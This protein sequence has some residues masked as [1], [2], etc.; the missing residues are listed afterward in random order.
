[1]KKPRGLGDVLIEER[2]IGEEQLVQAQRAALRQGSPLVTVLLE[3]NL[4]SESDLVEAI[5][6]RV[7]IPLFDPASTPVDPDAV[8]EVPYEEANRNRLLPVRMLQRGD[9]R[10]LKVAMADPLDAQAIE[11]LEF[12]S[13]AEVEPLVARYS[14]LGDAIRTHYR[15]V[16]TKV[17]PRDR[18]HGVPTKSL[19]EEPSARQIFSSARTAAR[20]RPVP[21]VPTEVNVGNQL[22]SLV[23][24]LVRKGVISREEFAAELR[25][26]F[27]F[28]EEE[29]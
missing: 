14:Q 5:R 17:I 18:N 24:L 22:Q 8:R 27:R 13:G 1:M 26:Q 9:Q 3:Q 25:A 6:R 21:R 10:V 16:V 12:S 11:D 15:G 4:V 20:T 2:L 23:N 19:R 29:K 7:Q 28:G